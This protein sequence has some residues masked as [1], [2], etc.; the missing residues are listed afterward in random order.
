MWCARSPT[1]GIVRPRRNQ[2]AIAADGGQRRAQLVRHFREQAHRLTIEGELAGR[3]VGWARSDFVLVRGWPL[4]SKLDGSSAAS[5]CVAT[6]A[7]LRSGSSVSSPSRMR[8][9]ISRNVSSSSR[10]SS[11]LCP[12]LRDDLWRRERGF[13]R[14]TGR[15][16]DDAEIGSSHV[17][18]RDRFA[19]TDRRFAQHLDV[20]AADQHARL[21]ATERQPFDHRID[22]HRP[23]RRPEV[24]RHG[25]GATFRLPGKGDEPRRCRQRAI[26]P[27][28]REARDALDAEQRQARSVGPNEG[29]L[30]G[31]EDQ[32]RLPIRPGPNPVPA[33]PCALSARSSPLASSPAGLDAHPC[34]PGKN[35]SSTFFQA[36]RSVSKVDGLESRTARTLAQYI[37]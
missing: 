18:S 12:A 14:R 15:R 21:V 24:E 34:Q 2:L 25:S 7:G 1:R 4:A 31:I 37:D 8:R 10:L 17:A 6:V 9:A 30:C 32:R 22:M 36:F 28:L 3:L 13:G 29:R 20:A 27:V 26:K 11:A 23:A 33:A 16:R 19:R 35:P 5:D